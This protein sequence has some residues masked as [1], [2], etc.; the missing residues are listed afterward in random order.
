MTFGTS[1]SLALGGRRS[2]YVSSEYRGGQ[3]SGEISFQDNPPAG[4]GGGLR[5][6]ASLG[7][8]RRTEAAYTY[9]LSMATVGAQVARAGGDT[10]VRVTATGSVGLIGDDAFASRSL[11]GSFANVRVDGHPG[12]RIYAEDQLIGVTGRD[13]SVT[14]PNL[15]PFEPNR[16]RIDESDLPLDAQL[17]S[18]ELVVRPFART[19][20]IVRFPVRRERGVLMHVKREDG[21]DLPAGATVELEGGGSFIFASGSEVY[22]PDLTGTQVL[23]VRWNGGACRFTATV[24][25]DD[26]PQPRLDGL[27]CRAEAVYASN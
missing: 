21:T 11:G 4:L 23:T 13:G 7:P 19:G 18:T 14:I 2:S 27:I 25:D 24:P 10:G 3:A 6:T 12:V 17:E 16:L 22:V 26:D 20:S 5:T 8:I 9:N 1:L 15:R